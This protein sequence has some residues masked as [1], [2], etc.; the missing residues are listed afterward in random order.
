[1]SVICCYMLYVCY[2]LCVCYVSSSNALLLYVYVCYML[3]YVICL[4]YIIYWAVGVS[5]HQVSEHREK[6]P[7]PRRPGQTFHCSSVDNST[8]SSTHWRQW[9]TAAPR[10]TTDSTEQWVWCFYAHA[11]YVICYFCHMFSLGPSSGSSGSVR[12]YR[13]VISGKQNWRCARTPCT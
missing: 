5:L 8:T 3:L 10:S 1:M 13:R 12:I 11:V 9:R 6:C 4:W 2:M 7:R